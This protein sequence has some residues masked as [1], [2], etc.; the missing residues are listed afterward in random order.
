MREKLFI[1][2]HRA[3]AI[4]LGLALLLTPVA[5]SNHLVTRHTLPQFAVLLLLSSILLGTLTYQLYL[6]RPRLTE[7]PMFVWILTGF[8]SALTLSSLT[9]IDPWISLQGS[10]TRQMGLVTYL[11]FFIVSISLAVCVRADSSTYIWTIWAMVV[12][13]A[14]VTLYG[15]G[16]LAGLLEVGLDPLLYLTNPKHKQALR[17]DSTL[18]H[19]DFAGNFLLYTLFITLGVL[20]ITKRL[21]VLLILLSILSI[22]VIL[23]TGT[24][25]AWLGMCAGLSVYFLLTLYYDRRHALKVILIA[26]A[27]AIT[28]ALVVV[29]TKI[30]ATVEERYRGIA[31]E[32]FS[33]AGRTTLWTLSQTMLKDYWSLGCG[34]EMYR[35]ASTRYKTEE[36][37]RKTSGIS[38]D[39]PHNL[40][41]STLLSSGI[42]ALL[43]LIWLIF[44]A[45][46]RLWRAIRSPHPLR[47]L[48][49]GLLSALVA[50]LAHSFFLFHIVPTG[51]YFFSLLTLCHLFPDL[52][53]SL[54]CSRS[55]SESSSG[56][57]VLLCALPLSFSS[58]YAHR[59][60]KAD[61]LALQALKAAHTGDVSSTLRYGR[62]C[63]ATELHQGDYH[64]FFAQA[65]ETLAAN[66]NDTDNEKYLRMAVTELEKSLQVSLE[67][68]FRLLNLAQLHTELREFTKA[69]QYIDRATQIDPLNPMVHLAQG[70]LYLKQGEYD[71]AIGEL[72]RARSRKLHSFFTRR[73]A[74]MLRQATNGHPQTYPKRK[75]HNLP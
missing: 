64:L 12:A 44:S 10:F 11:C 43:F 60:V 75:R 2:R 1:S 48:G 62:A 35:Q 36:Y 4:L 26:G 22:L 46:L 42:A 69:Q 7:F 47:P 18:G 56:V 6:H 37:V 41:L 14:L 9:S 58:I 25:G 3:S 40:Y 30:G 24:R 31:Q 70:G 54:D 21:R 68:E 23:S 57:I 32:G 39:D 16:Q 63:A 66:R 51:L 50:V 53:R 20:V 55:Y 73:L 71:K 52:G 28:L 72:N 67:L 49:I 34:L 15:L 33:A 38:S 13:G 8:I 45:L 74:L 27:C 5:L 19:P 61:Y 17:V 59:L 29:S 65:L